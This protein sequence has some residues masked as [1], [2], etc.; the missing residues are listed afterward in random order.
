[1]IDSLILGLSIIAAAIGLVVLL[2]ITG[3]IELRSPNNNKILYSSLVIIIL[4][5]V[6]T[7]FAKALTMENGLASND[8]CDRQDPPFWCNLNTE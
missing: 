1:M 8:E 6:L 5:L 7:L 4:G 2:L 3:I